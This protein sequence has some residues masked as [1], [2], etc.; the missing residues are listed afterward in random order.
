MTSMR[1]AFLLLLSVL[2]CCQEQIQVRAQSDPDIVCPRVKSVDTSTYLEI[3]DPNKRPFTEI[4]GL[5]FS[6]SQ[7]GPSGKPILY[8]MNDGGGGRRFGIF[9]SGSGVRLKSLRLP[10]TVSYNLDF[11]SMSVGTCGMD[12]ES[13]TCIYI[14]DVGDNTARHTG[15][16]RTGHDRPAYPIYR[17]TEPNPNDFQDND[18]L[19]ES[20]VT[21]LNFNYF[22]SS[23]PTRYSDCEA[24]FLD[25]KGYGEGGAPGDMYLV[26]KWGTSSTNIRLFK[27]PAHVWKQA[28]EDADFIYSPKA[29]GDY[30]KGLQSNSLMGRT[31]TR[32]EMTLDGTVIALGTFYDQYLFLRCPDMT[33]AR[34]LA[35]DGPGP[36]ESWPIAYWDSQF[37]TIAWSPDGAS[38]LEISECYGNTCKPNVPM[39]FTTM[40]YTYD[41]GRSWCRPTIPPDAPSSSPTSSP[42]PTVMPTVSSAPSTSSAPTASCSSVLRGA[43]MLYA[44]KIPSFICSP[45]GVYRFGVSDDSDLA[46]WRGDTKIWSAETCCQTTD[47][48]LIM[49]L[50]DA[51]L[52]LKSHVNFTEMKAIWS[53]GT[54][55][56]NYG[57]AQLSV[58]D[59]GQARIRF[60]G[61]EI[62]SN[63]NGATPVVPSSSPSSS[64]M[65]TVMPTV[66]SAPSTSPAP[67]APCASVLRGTEMLHAAKHPS[68]ICSPN[69]V[70]RFGVSD[71]SDLALWRGDTKIW[72]A[73]TCCQTTDVYL[74]MQLND[75]NLVLYSHVNFTEMKTI[76]SSGTANFNY[77]G[78][79][80]SVED[81]GQ[82]RIRF[83]GTEIWSNINGAISAS[84]SVPPSR[85]PSLVPPPAPTPR[86]SCS[87][88]QDK[89][90]CQDGGCKWKGG[91]CIVDKK[92]R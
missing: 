14:A 55:N 13:L 67:T 87:N 68:F 92:R 66:S 33:V 47:V 28:K 76:W 65:P 84:S 43:E 89:D 20:Y 30:S 88:F 69:G 48:Y 71:D 45:N 1:S 91:T 61:T 57:G 50:T 83:N 63:I 3:A 40:D 22:H 72:S 86:P 64:P 18:V 80:L 73:E 41:H 16:T 25:N 23:S 6:P 79:Q 75:A 81:D 19:P 49:Q 54:A 51:N 85:A 77:G 38:T 39:V 2:H 17:I 34:A 27:F 62:W 36:C 58:E 82:A 8:L 59:D 11:E 70:Y 42:M 90:S 60:N 37:E 74:I 21:T 4:S 15:G 52:V 29:V 31:W 56:F 9:D 5:G 46:L 7:V 10:R 24:M 78:A 44:D 32:A 53:S 35:A 12:E 26:T